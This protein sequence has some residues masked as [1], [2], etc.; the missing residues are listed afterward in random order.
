MVS[1]AIQ[2][3]DIPGA[4][5]VSPEH[6][7]VIHASVVAAFGAGARAVSIRDVSAQAAPVEACETEE[8]S[9]G[10]WVIRGRQIATEAHRVR[11][12]TETG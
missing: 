7:A 9:L 3:H 1:L 10:R 5:G 12:V 6:L 8:T 4:K 11:R 2:S